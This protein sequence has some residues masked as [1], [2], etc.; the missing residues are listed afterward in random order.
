M[1]AGEQTLAASSAG[2]SVPPT[3]ALHSS[4]NAVSDNDTGDISSRGA[5]DQPGS[6]PSPFPVHSSPSTGCH[7]GSNG[8]VASDGRN[9]RN[10]SDGSD[11][12]GAEFVIWGLTASILVRVACVVYGRR[13]P[14][15]EFHPE[16]PNY[17][18]VLAD[19][20]KRRLFL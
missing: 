3:G 20:A 8:S 16:A 2:A 4:T 10:G 6:V 12:S 18:T 1:G 15:G 9:G 5:M 19:L 13:A 11:G 7:L 14:F 17:P